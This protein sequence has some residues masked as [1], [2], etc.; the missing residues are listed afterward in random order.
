MARKGL[1][2]LDATQET[3]I[4]RHVTAYKTVTN[5]TK[6]KPGIRKGAELV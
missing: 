5:D 4:V 2:G 1:L 6:K 3:F